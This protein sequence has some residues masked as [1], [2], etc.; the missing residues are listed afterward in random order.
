MASQ[1][2]SAP[3]WLK[4]ACIGGIP[5]FLALLVIGA[6][7]LLKDGPGLPVLW[8]GMLGLVPWLILALRDVQDR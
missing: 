3:W 1:W 6:P 4:A 7:L 8:L 5:W 2:S